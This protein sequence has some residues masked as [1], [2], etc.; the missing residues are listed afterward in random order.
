MCQLSPVSVTFVIA[1]SMHF[2]RRCAHSEYKRRLLACSGSRTEAIRRAGKQ[3]EKGAQRLVFDGNAL[4]TLQKKTTF[5]LERVKT[6]EQC[7]YNDVVHE[8]NQPLRVMSSHLTNDSGDSVG[9]ISQTTSVNST[10][11]SRTQFTFTPQSFAAAL[12]KSDNESIEKLQAE[13]LKKQLDKK[14]VSVRVL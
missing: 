12:R 2:V 8:F 1:H 7:E 14:K 6:V 13:Q 4:K 5:V 10:D 11:N 3:Q 9:S